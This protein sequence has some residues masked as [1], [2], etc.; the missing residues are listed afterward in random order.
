MCRARIRNK[1]LKNMKKQ[2]LIKMIE[3]KIYVE[4]LK[5]IATLYYIK[6]FSQLDISFELNKCEKSIYNA[7]KEFDFSRLDD[8]EEELKDLKKQLKSKDK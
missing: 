2:D 4:E 6:E 3:E 5:D 1:E 8:I 7:L